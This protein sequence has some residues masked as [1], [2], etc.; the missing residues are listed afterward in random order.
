MGAFGERLRREREMRGITLEEMAA[1]TKISAR[2]LKYLEDE[3]FGQL[4]GGIF[5][6]GF[7]RAYAKFLGIDEEQAV[8]EYVAAAGDSNPA[9]DF[10]EKMAAAVGNNGGRRIMGTNEVTIA[11]PRSSWPVIAAIVLIGVVAFAAWTVYSRWKAERA[12]PVEGNR[13]TTSQRSRTGTITETSFGA[14]GTLSTARSDA[15]VQ[16]LLRARQDSWVSITADNKLLMSGMLNA[17]T[18]KSV[19]AANKIILKLGNAAGVE[20]SYNGRVLPRL[21]TAGEVRTVTFTPAGYQ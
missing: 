4:P 1:G 9:D 5:N 19:Q 8:S 11:E 13:P 16:L 10:L 7:V 14:G 20:I 3:R 21:G 12:T 2:S 18:Q 15:T 17:S 6:K